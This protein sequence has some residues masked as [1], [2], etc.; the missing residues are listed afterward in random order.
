MNTI[1]E[2]ALELKGPCLG[3]ELAISQTFWLESRF[4]EDDEDPTYYWWSN[5][6]NRSRF[7]AA[8]HSRVNLNDYGT[9]L[10]GFTESQTNEHTVFVRK[11]VPCCEPKGVMRRELFFTAR[12]WG[13]E[14]NKSLERA[15]ILYMRDWEARARVFAE[16]VD[17]LWDKVK[18]IEL[19]VV[20]PHFYQHLG[21]PISNKIYSV[22]TKENSV[23]NPRIFW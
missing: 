5:D 17:R 9:Y 14:E 8:M 19:S 15:V 20:D 18:R 11:D 7:N 22:I 13:E 6:Y 10:L 1:F 23:D 2:N 21:L 16:T 4:V 12:H 3:L